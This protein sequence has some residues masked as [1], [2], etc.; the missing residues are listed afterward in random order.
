[1]VW[2]TCV[3]P[4][5]PLC[6]S[7]SYILIVE[8]N[9]HMLICHTNHGGRP[10]IMRPRVLLNR[11]T[12]ASHVNHTPTSY[13]YNMPIPCKTRELVTW[14]FIKRFIRTEKSKD[15]AVRGKLEFTQLTP[16]GLS[17]LHYSH[18]TPFSAHFHC[19]YS[20]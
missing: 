17:P 7:T 16:M 1:M 11:A 13:N 8:N 20:A 10:N 2:Q 12:S 3:G 19:I 6:D 4:T 5:N 18:F 9:S 14:N 15:L